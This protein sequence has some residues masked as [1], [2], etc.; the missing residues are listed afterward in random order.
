MLAQAIY[1]QYQGIDFNL[2]SNY[3]IIPTKSTEPNINQA[4]GGTGYI[5]TTSS[6]GTIKESYTSSLGFELSANLQFRLAYKF[7]ISTGLGF[8]Y[9]NYDRNVIVSSNDGSLITTS[10]DNSS[11]NFDSDIYGEVFLQFS[12]DENGSLVLNSAGTSKVI[13]EPRNGET[14]L[15]FITIP[16]QIDYQLFKKLSVSTSINFNQLLFARENGTAYKGYDFQTREYLF[17]DVVHTDTDTFKNFQLTLGI[18]LSYNVWKQISLI[19]QFEKSLTNMYQEDYQY[20]DRIK[21]NRCSL[22]I[23]YSLVKPSKTE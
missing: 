5:V 11:L 19:G 12:N 4:S 3:L 9:S 8:L 6:I 23:S 18:G 13:A 22:G 16:V 20:V 21:F 15:G 10:L 2:K 17:E 7:T 1:A 14:K